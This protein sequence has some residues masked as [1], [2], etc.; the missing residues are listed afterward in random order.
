MIRNALRNESGWAVA[1]AVILTAVMLA[2]GLAAM[3]VVDNQQ[4][5]SGNQR[6]RE[7]ALNLDEAAVY[8]QGLVLTQNWPNASLATHPP[9]SCA[10]TTVNT[11]CPDRNTLAAASALTPSSAN[12]TST[13]FLKNATWI[14][15]IR[16]DGGTLKTFYDPTQADNAQGPDTDASGHTYTCPGPC[17]YDANGNHKVWV[18]ATSTVRGHPRAVVA[19]LQLEQLTED[20]PQMA[21]QAGKLTISNSGNHGGTA[22]VDG[23]GSPVMLRCDPSTGSACADIPNPIQVTPYPQQLP[24]GLSAP[25]LMTAAELQ[26]LKQRAIADGNYYSGCP[27]K[28]GPNNRYGDN[29]YHLEGQVVWVDNCTNPPQ[30]GNDV[31]TH[32]CPPSP[33]V[34]GGM[35]SN[36]INSPLSPG[37]LIWH[38]G[39]VQLSGNYTFC[40]LVYAVN[41][42]DEAGTPSASTGDVVTTTG[43]AAVWG[44]IAIDGMGRLNLGSNGEQLNYN[45]NVFSAIQTF[46]A[47]GLVQN[48]WRELPPNS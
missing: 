14:T 20:V 18:E 5:Q 25:P 40:G 37:V 34:P 38:V 32:P 19:Q 7:S 46:G 3:A 12:F 36:C 31:Y 9:A 42:S 45:P 10:P 35:S 29:Q 17:T 39:S 28:G 33:T 41:D 27:T 22:I 16:D 1:T 11:W 15:R 6:Q 26:R 2:I 24:G 44:A 43:G 13:D 21:M 4:K 30:L 47:A 8:G 48:T 23:G